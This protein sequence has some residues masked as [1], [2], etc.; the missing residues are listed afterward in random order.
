MSVLGQVSVSLEVRIRECQAE[1][2]R[3]LE[4]FGLFTPHQP[5]LAPFPF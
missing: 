5:T 3:P 2:L 1:D 4:W